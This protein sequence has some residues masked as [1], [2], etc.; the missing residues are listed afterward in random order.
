M[1]IR[2]GR[3]TCTSRIDPTRARGGFS[4]A[5]GVPSIRQKEASFACTRTGIVRVH[6]QE[7]CHMAQTLH[8]EKVVPARP[9]HMDEGPDFHELPNP[10]G[11]K[12]LIAALGNELLMD[13]GVGVHA[14]R[15]LQ[16]EELQS[17]VMAVEVGTAVL[18]AL[19]L[20]EWADKLLAI[21]AVK[22]GSVPGTIYTFDIGKAGRQEHQISLHE[23]SL[24][25]A[26]RLIPADMMPRQIMVV[27]IEPEIIHYGME[28]SPSVRAAFPDVVRA[29]K[30][31]VG[32]WIAEGKA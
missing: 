6:A 25:G 28:L 20:F 4:L 16:R 10:S 29:V 21:D 18:D 1:A 32:E 27:G 2:T 19:H 23:L 5:Q 11:P 15:E 22:A 31:I 14:V 7:T 24:L 13:D 8:S 9:T 30:Q 17:G 12:I 3:D 26:L